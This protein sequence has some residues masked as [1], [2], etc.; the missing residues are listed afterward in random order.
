MRQE[1]VQSFCEEYCLQQR[2]LVRA[3]EV[4]GHLCGMLRGFA[5]KGTPFSSCGDDHVTV[6]KCL[7]SGYFSNAA[8]LSSSGDYVTVRGNIPVTA[9]PN[10]IIAR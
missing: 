8:K 9:H 1:S 6:R 2:I 7:V 10:S 5:E 3:K 4:R